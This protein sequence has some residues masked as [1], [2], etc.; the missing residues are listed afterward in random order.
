MAV[1]DT[2]STTPAK[3]KAAPE[4]ILSKL[5]WDD[6]TDSFAKMAI[7]MA[8]KRTVSDRAGSIVKW[9]DIPGMARFKKD[10]TFTVGFHVNGRPYPFLE[11]MAS[12]Q[13]ELKAAVLYEARSATAIRDATSDRSIPRAAAGSPSCAGSRPRGSWST[14]SDAIASSTSCSMSCRRTACSPGGR[15]WP[16][17]AGARPAASDATIRRISS[18][19][20]SSPSATAAELPRR[21]LRPCCKEFRWLEFRRGPLMSPAGL[22]RF[23]APGE[24]SAE[25]ILFLRS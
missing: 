16:P 10:R 11:I 2:K 22:S 15:S 9:S 3:G 18:R 12:M 25:G 5:L 23:D 17:P 24:D 21:A 7:L 6:G 20:R 13:K 8:I 19:R 1:K 14:S 4:V